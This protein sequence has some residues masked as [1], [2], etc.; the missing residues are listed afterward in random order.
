M[1]NDHVRRNVLKNIAV[2]SHEL[3]QSLC[4]EYLVLHYH[5]LRHSAFASRLRLNCE[6]E[7][8]GGKK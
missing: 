3:K 2:K 6:I 5:Q 4:R 1:Q 7:S 8:K